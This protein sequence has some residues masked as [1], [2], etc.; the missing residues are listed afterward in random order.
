MQV[1]RLY[2]TTQPITQYATLRAALPVVKAFVVPQCRM[3]TCRF[4]TSPSLWICTKY[5]PSGRSLVSKWISS[6]FLLSAFWCSRPP[7]SYKMT[8]KD[9]ELF[10]FGVGSFSALPVPIDTVRVASAGFGNTFHGEYPQSTYS[11]SE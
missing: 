10:A 8:E 9:D 3:T 4:S 7:L 2:S 5:V 1:P 11:N 6:P